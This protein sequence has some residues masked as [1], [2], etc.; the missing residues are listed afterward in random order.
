MQSIYRDL[1]KKKKK[2]I[3]MSFQDFMYTIAA[4]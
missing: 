2:R 1:K 3:I 4:F